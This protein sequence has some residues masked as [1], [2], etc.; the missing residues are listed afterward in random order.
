VM[1]PSSSDKERA[2]NVEER[3]L[4]RELPPG[5]MASGEERADRMVMPVVR[6]GS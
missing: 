5:E 4:G 2:E 3:E 6:E 1:L